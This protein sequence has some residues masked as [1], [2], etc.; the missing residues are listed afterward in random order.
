MNNITEIEH[1]IK[2]SCWIAALM[3]GGPVYPLSRID[4]RD[5]DRSYGKNKIDI[6]TLQLRDFN[7]ADRDSYWSYYGGRP[8]FYPELVR[9]LMNDLDSGINWSLT[10]NIK[11]DEESEFN[12]SY[13]PERYV[14]VVKGKLIMN[15]GNSY[16][17]IANLN[18]NLTG[19]YEVLKFMKQ[20]ENLSDEEV[21]ERLKI[22][23]EKSIT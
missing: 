18:V 14:P 16:H 2:R 20:W 7:D 11:D 9:K 22:K 4:Y 10:E 5:Y 15:N 13:S 12:G 1:T 17:W 23:L 6:F 19:I 21:I 8:K 3:Y